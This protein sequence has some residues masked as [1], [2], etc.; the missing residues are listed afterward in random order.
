M[1]WLVMQSTKHKKWVLAL[2]C[3]QSGEYQVTDLMSENVN[4]VICY[5]DYLNGKRMA[6]A[7]ETGLPVGLKAAEVVLL[8]Q[9]KKKY[10]M[11]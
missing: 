1:R 3:E 2:V 11:G 7:E 9:T 5:A 6:R 4:K 10:Q 8:D